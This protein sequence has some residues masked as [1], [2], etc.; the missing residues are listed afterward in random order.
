MMHGFTDNYIRVEA[1]YDPI[2]INEIMEVSLSAI[3]ET[4]NMQV[5]EWVDQPVTH[6]TN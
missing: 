1:K 2:L 4:G 6:M 3:G 5:T